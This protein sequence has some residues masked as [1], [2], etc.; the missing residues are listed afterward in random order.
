M[1]MIHISST[2]KVL[3]V[4]ALAFAFTATAYGQA[5]PLNHFELASDVRASAR[6]L[7][8]KGEYQAA[9]VVLNSLEAGKYPVGDAAM[10]A[11]AAK[12]QGVMTDKGRILIKLGRYAEADAAFYRAFDANIALA[13]KDI[14][15]VQENGT[16]GPPSPG[17]KAWDAFISARGSLTRADGVV[18][19][20]EASYM[21]VGAAD[22]AKPFD[23]A[24]LAKYEALRKAVARFL[25]R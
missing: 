12:I 21:L 24:R 7:A 10:Q 9:L 6:D 19:L 1:K 15:Y 13:A 4:L 17:S 8:D 20:R 18:D 23:A 25:P 11:A 16:G 22:A 14:E 3:G 2:I 5:G